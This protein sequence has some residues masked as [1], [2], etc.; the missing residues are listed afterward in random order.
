LIKLD[1]AF[2]DEANMLSRVIRRADQG[3]FVNIE[4]QYLPVFR[5]FDE[6]RMIEYA[7]VTF[8]PNH[9]QLH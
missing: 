8:E 1:Q 7:Q 6:W 4:W 5:S 2:I 9:P 3:G